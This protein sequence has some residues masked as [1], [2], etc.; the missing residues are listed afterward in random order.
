MKKPIIFT[1]SDVEVKAKCEER[2]AWLALN[3]VP[4]SIPLTAPNENWQ[5]TESN[6]LIPL[7]DE[8]QN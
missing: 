3:K 6:K 2:T 4:T 7:P 5:F 1:K 8:F